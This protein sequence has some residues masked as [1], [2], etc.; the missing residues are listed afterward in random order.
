MRSSSVAISSTAARVRRSPAIGCWVAMIM[1]ASFSSSKR[2]TLMRWSASISDRAFARSWRSRAL[3]E[4]RR[5]ASAMPP[6]LQDPPGQPLQLL[7]EPFSWHLAFLLAES[8]RDVILGAPVPRAGE[9]LGGGAVLGQEPAWSS[10]IQ[11]KPVKSD[12]RAACCM[13]CVTMTMV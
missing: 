5:A 2:I 12:T 11:K 8:A 13:L 6:Q 7:L 4:S 10:P 9:D 3:T 1:S